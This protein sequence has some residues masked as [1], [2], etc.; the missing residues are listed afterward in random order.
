MDM[1]LTKNCKNILGTSLTLLLLAGCI[2]NTDNNDTCIHILHKMNEKNIYI[3][4]WNWGINGNSQLVAISC[5]KLK[6]KSEVRKDRDILYEGYYP[7]FIKLKGDSLLIY[8]YKKTNKPASYNLV[9]VPVRQIE[10][11]NTDNMKL[12]VDISYINLEK[13][14]D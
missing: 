5:T 3:H 4:K 2:S 1:A 13:I 6:N 7:I 12:R 14:C 8:T 10:I 11:D 9:N